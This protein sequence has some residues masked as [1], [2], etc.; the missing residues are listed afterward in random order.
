M[1]LMDNDREQNVAGLMLFLLGGLAGTALALR[2]SRGSTGEGLASR[3]QGVQA[4]L[5]ETV[6]TVESSVACVRRM[7]TPMQE[8]LQEANVLAAGIQRTVDS[9]RSIGRSA[10][11]PYVPAMADSPRPG[12]GP[13]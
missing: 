11:A 4:A 12:A 10:D 13:S 9:Y 7:A 5:D 2:W 1:V 8:L 3:I 6:A